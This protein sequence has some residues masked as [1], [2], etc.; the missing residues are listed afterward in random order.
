MKY[1]SEIDGLRALAVLPVI[2]FHAGFSA[3]SGGFLGVDI[4]FVISGYLITSII[5]DDIAHGKFSIARF[6]E[7]RARRILPALFCVLLVTIVGAL[8]WMLPSQ[9]EVFARSLI[10]TIFFIPNLFFWRE[11]SYFAADAAQQPLLHT[12]S[13]GV[14]EQFYVLFPLAILFVWRFGKRPT[15]A[16][17][18][19]AGLISFIL[20]DYA[21]RMMPSANFFLLPTRAWELI[22]GALCAFAH[23]HHAPRKQNLL[24]LLGLTL[25]AFSLV[26]YGEHMPLPSAYTL[27]PVVGTALII[28][29]ATADS[30]VGRVLS[31]R[32]IV[33]I[34]LISYSAY[35][36]HHP[37][38]AFARIREVHA[39]DTLTLL[40]LVTSALVLAAFTWYFIEQPFRNKAHRYYVN[41]RR[42]L[43]LAILT[44]IIILA[45]GIHGH[46]TQGRLEAWKQHA[47]S[48]QRTALILMQREQARSF[49]YDNDDCR[50]NMNQL[51]EADE[52]RIVAC[53]KTY[54]AGTAV[55]GDSHAMNLFHIL[56]HSAPDTPF[57]VGFAQGMCRPYE[58]LSTCNYTP[59]LNMLKRHPS[60]FS[61]VIYE[62]AGWEMLRDLHHRPLAQ[63][64]ISGLP[65]N[66][67]VPDFTPNLESIIAT[68]DYLAQLAP[69]ATITWLGPRLEPE[70]SE[71][72]VIQRGCDYAFTLRPN[73]EAVFRGFD[74][75]IHNALQGYPVHYISQI[76]LMQ[77]D[78]NKDFMHC[79]ATYWKDRN[80]YSEEGEKHFAT[81]ITLDAIISDDYE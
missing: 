38:F 40:A 26:S 24:G 73:Q 49:E 55:I 72:V 69:F 4:F 54:G 11:S 79:D 31:L 62:Q 22:I 56:R 77:F 44:A 51:S 81:R 43:C 23:H 18:I 50:F 20:C 76:D 37:I 80:H 13:L 16:L 15:I 60:L 46:V 36:W 29:F 2:L 58:T 5:L 66:A 7:R 53:S 65:L 42:A 35:L 48:A 39:P 14:E 63:D 33:A 28:L 68:R 34:G 17:L 8:A 3:V 21:S 10:A 59:F 30:W 67:R 25:I 47:S 57:L 27:L 70:I 1:R 19:V 32:P 41:G 12:W 71:N 6:Y 74:A 52:P 45:V 9:Y 61:Q 75:A 78:M 64:M